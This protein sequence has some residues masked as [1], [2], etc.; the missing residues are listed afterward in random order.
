[1]SRESIYFQEEMDLYAS[2][3]LTTAWTMETVSDGGHP[4]MAWRQLDAAKAQTIGT[5]EDF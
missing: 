5:S 3:N 2:R 4:V 1:M